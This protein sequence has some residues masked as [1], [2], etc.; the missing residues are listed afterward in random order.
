M[1]VSGSSVEVRSF[2][3]AKCCQR[4][5]QTSIY[6]MPASFV[7]VEGMEGGGIDSLSRFSADRTC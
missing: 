5:R 1:V 6:D 4:G 7:S 3:S 2:S